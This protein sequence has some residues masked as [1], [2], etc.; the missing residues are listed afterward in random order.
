[1]LVCLLACSRALLFF[2]F[3]FLSGILRGVQ[4]QSRRRALRR[5]YGRAKSVAARGSIASWAF[6]RINVV[7]FLVQALHMA[8][9]HVGHGEKMSDSPRGGGSQRVSVPEGINL[10]HNEGKLLEAQRLEHFPDDNTSELD[11]P[12]L[13]QYNEC[14]L[15]RTT[16][17]DY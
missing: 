1:M 6:T 2:F 15:S 12:K 13:R 16:S 11:K 9:V 5:L 17:S 4:Q 8:K 7:L 14:E 3:F 10:L